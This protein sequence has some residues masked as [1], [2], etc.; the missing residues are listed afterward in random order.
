MPATSL[1]G[2]LTDAIF[3]GD[4]WKLAIPG[5]LY[6]L[7]N[8]LQYIGLSNL[9]AATFQATYQLRL[10]AAAVFGAILFKRNL[11][12]AKWISLVLLFVGV[13]IVQFPGSDPYDPDH[14]AHLHVPRSL[15]DLK[16]MG[17]HRLHKRSATYEGIEEDLMLGNPHLNGKIGLLA[18]VGACVASGL[19]GVSFEKVLKD[20][21]SSTSIWI[22]NVQLAV[23]SIFP[24]LFIGVVFLDGEKVAK[25]GFFGGYNWVVWA[26]IGV[27]AIGG[28]ATSFCISYAESALKN[29]AG[30]L[31][32]VITSLA[33]VWAFDFNVGASVSPH[34]FPCSLCSP[35]RLRN[36]R[37][38]NS[39]F[40][41]PHLSWP[42]ST[43]T[44]KAHLIIANVPLQ[45]G[46]A[47][48]RNPISL[49]AQIPQ[50]TL[51][52]RQMISPSN[53]PQRRLYQRPRR[54]LRRGLG[55][56]IFIE[57]LRRVARISGVIIGRPSY[58]FFALF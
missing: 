42:Q 32:I 29:S 20:S 58:T 30:A 40:L 56:P 49:L 15:E 54:P 23:Y 12:F 16:H 47:I 8:S 36:L 5:G 9:E 18:T 3:S 31:S 38:D 45:F 51:R 11:T 25:V 44:S 48:W 13:A 52:R 6:T 50:T 17:E 2:S 21:S 22:R 19:A 28:I 37:S 26:T 7:A 57:M 39:S 24:A 14:R 1:F 43:S 4:S 33:S 53:S 35:F 46:L 27:H 10:I 55:H 34:L 41:A